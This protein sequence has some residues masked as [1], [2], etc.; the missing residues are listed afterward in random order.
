MNAPTRPAPLADG[1]GEV[2]YVGGIIR[3]TRAT[4][5]AD[6]RRRGFVHDGPMIVT[7]AHCDA[8]LAL[9]AHLHAP[10]AIYY[11]R[12][13]A[14]T[15]IREDTGAAVVDVDSIGAATRAARKAVR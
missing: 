1:I 10:L 15:V 8:V 2:R 12:D 6:S 11:G 14:C 5:A 13:G 3:S 4:R 9:S 7:D